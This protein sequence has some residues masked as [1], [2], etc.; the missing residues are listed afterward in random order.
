LIGINNICT[1]KQD[2]KTIKSSGI[3]NHYSIYRDVVN[4][5]S[6]HE[7]VNSTN[8]VNIE[9]KD[10]FVSSQEGKPI[11]LDSLKEKI[12][13]I[14]LFWQG[15]AILEDSEGNPVIA[16]ISEVRPK[17][18]DQ[19]D[20]WYNPDL[21]GIPYYPD[22]KWHDWWIDK[23]RHGE[24][25]CKILKLE[26]NNEVLGV[27]MI[28]S[29]LHNYSDQRLVTLIRGLRVSPTCSRETNPVPDYKSVGTALVTYAA[30]DSIKM[31]DTGITVN[32][33]KGS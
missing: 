12:P 5:T 14:K 26:V 32:S 13:D 30:I 8:A 3:L 7:G 18:S 19:V 25:N 33:S 2:Y 22:Q 1:A 15:Q 4:F 21:E 29:S 24:E 6:K 27:L 17:D 11:N 16:Q 9:Q 31:N 20:N 10:K 28:N 23:I